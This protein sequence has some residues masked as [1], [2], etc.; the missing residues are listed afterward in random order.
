MNRTQMGELAKKY[1]RE[2]LYILAI[3]TIQAI[4]ESDEYSPD[5]AREIKETIE[6]LDLVRPDESL[7]WKAKRPQL[8]TE[9][10][11]ENITL[12]DTPEWSIEQILRNAG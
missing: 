4:I 2:D 11:E 12:D 5:K 7:P 9:V 6:S 3:G 8:H 10:N 1:G